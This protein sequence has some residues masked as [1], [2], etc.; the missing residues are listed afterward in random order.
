MSDLPMKRRSLLG[1]VAG[2]PV[3]GRCA[4]AGPPSFRLVPALAPGQQWRFAFER[5]VVRGHAAMQWYR[6]PLHVR[7]LATDADGALL[8]WVEGEQA[9]YE[10]R[11]AERDYERFAQR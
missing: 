4:D 8:E 11:M 10:V 9:I 3:F 1:L 5:K 7:V 6:A 2:L